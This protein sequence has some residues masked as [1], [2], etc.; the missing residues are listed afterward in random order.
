MLQTWGCSALFGAERE[1]A[2]GGVGLRAEPTHHVSGGPRAQQRGAER[3]R[4]GGGR[5]A[6]PSGSG[7]D[8]FL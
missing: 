3:S 1:H 4:V 2:E 7:Q 6:P 8:S 5:G